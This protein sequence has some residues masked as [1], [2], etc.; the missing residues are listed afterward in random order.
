M[1]DASVLVVVVVSAG[2]TSG[3]E[4]VAV[5]PGLVVQSHRPSLEFATIAPADDPAPSTHGEAGEDC[6]LVPKPPVVATFPP[7]AT[8]RSDVEVLV[9]V[10]VVAPEFKSTT[11]LA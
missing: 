7:A 3:I 9:E 5:L 4:S 11:G 10:E 2:T 6:A 8:I 1:V